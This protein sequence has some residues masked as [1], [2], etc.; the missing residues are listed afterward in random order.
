M[1]KNV[2]FAINNTL[3]WIW[4]VIWWTYQAIDAWDKKIWEKIEKKMKEKWKDTT[5]KVKKFFR[6]NILKILLWAWLLTH[7]WVEIAQHT[8]DQHKEHTEIAE[9]TYLDRFWDDDKIFIIDVSEYNE[10]NESKFKEWNENRWE[11]SKEDV[12]WV[13]WIYIR[14]QKEWWA[15]AD[16]EKFYEWIKRYNESAEQGQH[17]AVWWYI[18]FN[19]AKS[20]ITDEWIERQVDDAIS[21][22]EIINDDT[23][24]I[25]DLVPMLDFEFTNDPWANSDRWKKCKEAVLQRLQLF[26]QKT[27]I[28]P[29]IYTWWSIYHDYFLNDSR[30]AEYPVRIATYN[31]KRVDQSP[32]WHSVLIWP[33]W[34]PAT[35]QPDLVQFTEQ[36]TWSWFWTEWRGKWF[37]DWSTTTKDRFQGLIIRNGDAP[38]DLEELLRSQNDNTETENN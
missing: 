3:S 19:K 6:N 38:S 36:I 34:N 13:S 30:F 28:V 4:N 29:W 26:E 27:W 15:D 14:I 37:L 8:K 25:V 33:I 22:L 32:D 11:S 23:D 24:W 12:R 7:W 9:W 20:A 17:I 18:Y 31:W 5:W 16:F 10:L 2:W 1:A 21:R 35:F